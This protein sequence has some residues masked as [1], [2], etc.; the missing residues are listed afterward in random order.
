[1]P[2]EDAYS[3]GHQA[4][5]HCGTCKCSNIET[6][7]SRTCLV[8]WLLSFEYPSVLLSLSIVLRLNPRL[9]ISFSYWKTTDNRLAVLLTKYRTIVDLERWN[10][11]PDITPL[12]F[13]HIVTL[14]ILQNN[15]KTQGI[16]HPPCLLRW[17]YVQSKEGP[18][19]SEFHLVGLKNG[20]NSSTSTVWPNDH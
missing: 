12:N 3:S 11:S 2:R 10:E 18:R 5:S 14:K 15:D 4:L 17:S 1:M 20:K 19:R 13:Q 7:H 6:N 8:S 16:N 9:N